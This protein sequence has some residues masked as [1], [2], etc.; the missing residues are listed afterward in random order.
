MESKPG[1]G[2]AA[3][4]CGGGGGMPASTDQGLDPLSVKIT[5][6]SSI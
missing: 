1:L 6:P 3:G 4:V 5:L 2:G